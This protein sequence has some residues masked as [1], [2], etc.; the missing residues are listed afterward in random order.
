MG[1]ILAVGIGGCA[2]LV[3]LGPKAPKSAPER[4]LEKVEVVAAELTTARISIESQGEVEAQRR[5]QLSA[6]VPGKVVS[7]ASRLEA[8]EV[9]QEGDLLLAL[10]DADYQA[11]LANAQAALEDARLALEVELARAEQARRDWGKLGVSRE[12]NDLVLRKPQL[13]SARARITAS[14]AAVEKALR[15]L[16]RTEI[17]APYGC[18]IER[19]MVDLGAVI[20]PGAPLVEVVSLGAVEVRLPLSLEDYGYLQRDDDGMVTGTVTA[21]AR[22]GGE[23]FEWTGRL[24]R[25]EEI[26]DAATQSIPVVAQ[27]GA[28]GETPPPVGIFLEAAIAGREVADVVVVDRAAM[29][30]PGEVLVVNADNRIAFR[31]VK[32]VRTEPETVLVS[33]GLAPGDLILTTA[34]STPVSNMEVEIVGGAGEGEPPGDASPVSKQPSL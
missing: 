31:K 13:A 8:G 32:V 34:L 30:S 14:E 20:A 1:G 16:E 9:F 18:R 15:D 33:E 17:R 23:E 28:G 25:S 7:V 3:M 11:A 29:V 27:F 10:E 26:V 5:T 21:R 22:I 24:V 6:E 19:T 2:A 12:P 4:R